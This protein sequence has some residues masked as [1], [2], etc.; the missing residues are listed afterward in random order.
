M[1][2]PHNMK[3]WLNY[4]AKNA[5]GNREKLMPWKNYINEEDGALLSVKL[6]LESKKR[7]LLN[8]PINL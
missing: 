7:I 8:I 1:F 3:D 2:C 6:H 4:H 5:S